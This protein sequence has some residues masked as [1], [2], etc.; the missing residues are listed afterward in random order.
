MWRRLVR[1]PA[2]GLPSGPT[3]ISPKGAAARVP[4]QVHC[5]PVTTL[6][7]LGLQGPPPFAPADRLLLGGRS[8][9]GSVSDGLAA[10]SA[11]RAAR[12][13]ALK[14]IEEIVTTPAAPVGPYP[15][16]RLGTVP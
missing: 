13:A 4:C 5:G 16:H 9:S 1:L 12:R 15:H 11:A 2:I 8:G 7:A 10:E 6:R 14:L 3:R